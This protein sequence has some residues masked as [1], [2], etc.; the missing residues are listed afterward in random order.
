MGSGI[1]LA[2]AH[3]GKMVSPG[4]VSRVYNGKATS[5]RIRTAIETEIQRRLKTKTTPEMEI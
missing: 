2:Y 5:A 3:A 1:E 4:H